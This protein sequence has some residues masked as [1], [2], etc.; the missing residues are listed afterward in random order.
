MTTSACFQLTAETAKDLGELF[1][2]RQ[3]IYVRQDE[4][5]NIVNTFDEPVKVPVEIS[6]LCKHVEFI[7]Q[8]LVK[9]TPNVKYG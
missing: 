6:Q 8:P 7:K 3:T 1:W 4:R 2:K 5:I 9:E